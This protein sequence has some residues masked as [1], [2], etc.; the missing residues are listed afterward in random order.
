M[1][2]AESREG[3][4]EKEEPGDSSP[5]SHGGDLEADNTFK[6]PPELLG[7]SWGS[8]L[9][10]LPPT[11]GR[12]GRRAVISDEEHTQ[13]GPKRNVRG[14]SQAAIDHSPPKRTIPLTPAVTN[15]GAVTVADGVDNSAC[16]PHP[17]LRSLIVTLGE[18]QKQLASCGIDSSPLSEACRAVETAQE[19]GSLHPDTATSPCAEATAKALE[20]VLAAVAVQAGK[21]QEHAACLQLTAERLKRNQQQFA[22]EQRELHQAMNT[23]LSLIMAEKVA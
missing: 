20:G 15:D 14:Q 17:L 3:G 4:K 18:T 12:S 21:M 10:S 11:A 1:E 9:F 7:T 5:G 22:R 16:Q 23:T 8:Y 19:E 2:K 6:Y 13:A